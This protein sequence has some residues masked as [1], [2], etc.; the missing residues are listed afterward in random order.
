[1]VEA[2]AR[3]WRPCGAGWYGEK[4]IADPAYVGCCCCCWKNWRLAAI[5]GANGGRCE[6]GIG[7]IGPYP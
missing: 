2:G 6:L 5:D 1:M 4:P 7:G 3:R